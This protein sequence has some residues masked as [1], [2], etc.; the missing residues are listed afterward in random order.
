MSRFNNIDEK[1]GDYEN[2]VIHNHDLDTIDPTASLLSHKKEKLFKEDK[3]NTFT[4]LIVCCLGIFLCYFYYGIVQEKITK[5]EYETNGFVEKFEYTFNLLLAQCIVNSIFSKAVLMW[6]NKSGK[7]DNTPTWLLSVCS[8]SYI[9]AMLTSNKALE[10]VNYPTQV[11]GKSIKPIPVMILGVILAKKRYPIRKYVFV[12]LIV[13]GVTLF[14]FKNKS[15]RTYDS[16]ALKFGE[17]LLLISLLLD[18]VTGALQEKMRNHTIRPHTMMLHF[19]QWSM[20][21]M[22][23]GIFLTGEGPKFVSFIHRHPKVLLDFL[24]FGITSA[25]GQHFIFVTVTDFGPLT[26]SLVTTTRKFFTILASVI[27]FGNPMNS[28]QWWGTTLV[29]IGLMLDTF[30]GKAIKKPIGT[31]K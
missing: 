29:F 1:L 5:S 28:R 24:V 8:M 2:G 9:G 3:K 20:L 22:S 6:T 17:I 13:L 11:L 16:T 19:N 31:T 23:L 30:Y 18:G 27:L 26:C 10:Y 7:E 21:Y 4:K 12:M 15:A 14:L 25:L